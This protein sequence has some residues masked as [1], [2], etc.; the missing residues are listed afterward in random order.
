VQETRA[1]AAKISPVSARRLRERL[2]HLQ[3]SLI[4][5]LIEGDATDMQRII[6]VSHI[7]SCIEVVELLAGDLRTR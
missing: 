3:L 6:A 1:M 4:T 5:D 2:Q 7:R